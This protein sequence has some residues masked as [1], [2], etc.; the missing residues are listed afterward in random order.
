[1]ATT[2]TKAAIIQYL[3]SA[4]IPQTAQEISTGIPLHK[5]TVHRALEQN[6]IPGIVQ[7]IE[8]RTTGFRKAVQYV[9]SE[10]AAIA[11]AKKYNDSKDPEVI[12]VMPIKNNS[13]ANT[14][15]DIAGLRTDFHEAIEDSLRTP[16]LTKR[17]AIDRLY[18][19]I[20]RMK[21]D[22]NQSDDNLMEW[23]VI[24]TGTA[25]QLGIDLTKS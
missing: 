15:L 21:A 19:G 17:Q 23:L 7:I 22:E 6:N 18:A 2:K 25:F 20:E 8:K 5:T 3:M 12:A 1:M 24:I 13:L 4:G 10:E 9:Y 14:V 11:A 16:S